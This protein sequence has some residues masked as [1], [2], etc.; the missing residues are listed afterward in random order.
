MTEFKYTFLPFLRQG[1]GGLI[2]DTDNHAGTL[3]KPRASIIVKIEAKGKK[4]SD[5]AEELLDFDLQTD[6]QQTTLEKTVEIYGP[7]DIIGVNN[8]AVVRTDPEDWITN[9][10]PN[11]LPYIE[12]WDE[13]FPW[14]YTPLA[15][16]GTNNNEKKLR[17]WMTLVALKE[18]EFEKVAEFNGILPSFKLKSKKF[19]DVF[20]SEQTLWAWASV[21]I[22]DALSESDINAALGSLNTKLQSNPALAVSRIMCP[23]RLDANTGYYCFLIPTFEIGR[24]A[25]LGTV[26]E[27][28]L[29]KPAWTW[30]DQQESTLE[31]PYYYEWF[32][33]TGTAGDFE[34]LANLLQPITLD[35]TLVG[36]R[37]MDIQDP[38][39]IDLSGASPLT[40]DTIDLPGA[41]RPARVEEEPADP[42]WAA[43]T[44]EY[45]ATDYKIALKDFV[46]TSTSYLSN[47]TNNEDPVITPPMYGRWHAKVNTLDT[48]ITDWLNKVNLDP[49][50]RVMASAGAEAVR[51]NQEIFMQM[52]WEQVKDIEEANRLINQ[53]ELGV[54]A[55]QSAYD[56]SFDSVSDEDKLLFSSNVHARVIGDDNETVY[57]NV[58]NS[59]LPNGCFTGSFVKAT[60]ANGFLTGNFSSGGGAISTTTLISNLNSGSIA[61]AQLYAA[62]SGMALYSI[63]QPNM[64]TSSFTTSLPA[65]PTFALTVPSTF[66]NPGN[67]GTS[68]A[69]FIAF[70]AAVAQVHNYI[71]NPPA[72][73]TS[74]P[75]L[76]ISDA[77]NAISDTILPTTSVLGVA[78]RCLDVRSTTGSAVAFTAVKPILA[79]PKI[80]LPV[81]DY[82]YDFSPDMLM[83]NLN[84][85]PQNSV[86]LMEL[87]MDMIESYLVGMNHEMASELLWREYPT[88]QRGTVFSKFWGSFKNADLDKTRI[89]KPIHTWRTTSPAGLSN[90]G[91]NSPTTFNPE[92]ILVLALR[93]ELLKKYPNTL[94]YAKKAVWDK[95]NNVDDYAKPRIP[96]SA[97][98]SLSNYREPI[99]FSQAGDIA[100][101][102][103]ELDEAEIKGT[104]FNDQ[105]VPADAQ[106]TGWFF[107]F[108][109]MIGEIH[110]GLDEFSATNPL[111]SPSTLS[112]WDDIN[113]GHFDN[114]SVENI[115]FVKL[116]VSFPNEL[117]DQPNKLKWNKNSADMAGILLRKPAYICIHAKELI[118]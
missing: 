59:I 49:K 86:S 96:D 79:C 78:N 107:I 1:I 44:S 60:R 8:D 31:F 98:N 23:R 91:Q 100:F 35:S 105:N 71:G 54:E 68:S 29:Q 102:G 22:N 111:V 76:G 30:A 24:Q 66:Y 40:P 21:H 17:P 67:G 2:E 93:G 90:L 61:V 52:A 77:A 53:L 81:I 89:I 13:D 45:D 15:P 106:A 16:S 43:P 7:G 118:L 114:L 95:T 69:M 47:G 75:P 12:F 46:N 36:K 103:F 116:D 33:K 101:F 5:G 6:G 27:T 42:W 26:T 56:R 108:K 34:A 58:E 4:V 3:Q 85:L 64:L 72:A 37:L 41:L 11:Y 73:Q 55:G 48:S 109:E 50:F 10:E 115:K 14:R 80:E 99:F 94:I 32:F 51:K 104:T 112:N 20:P 19:E 65:R 57:A 18:D 117:Q 70:N 28:N 87:N 83:P 110:Y 74:N 25:G 39:N 82:L 9:F 113:W 38:G 84:A 63:L 92:N 97:T 62:P 88:D